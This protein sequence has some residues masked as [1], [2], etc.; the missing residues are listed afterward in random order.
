MIP[1][2]SAFVRIW[3]ESVN[4]I[5]TSITTR[6][7]IGPAIECRLLESGSCFYGA[8]LFPDS[9]VFSREGEEN[10]TSCLSMTRREREVQTRPVSGAP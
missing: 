7:M 2:L 10:S 9:S 6:L 5:T 8:L 3:R 1:H 4:S